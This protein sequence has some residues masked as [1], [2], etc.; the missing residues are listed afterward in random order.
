MSLRLCFFSS[1]ILA[2]LVAC[3]GSS[4]GLGDPTQPPPDG[5]GQ[6]SSGST[7]NPG[8][9]P[10]ST[11]PASGPRVAIKVRGTTAAVVHEDSWSGETPKKQIVAIRS[12]YLLR[13]PTDANPVQVFDHGAKAVESDLISGKTTEVASVI[14][15]T[16]P[17]GVFTVAKA[18]VAYVRYAV[19]ARMHSVA[20]VDCLYDNVQALSDGAV[21]DGVNR[22]KG[23]F[24]YSFVASGTTYGTLEGEDAPVPA[25]GEHGGL[26]LDAS[27]PQAFYVFPV[28]LAIDPNV[29]QDHEV[30]LEINVHESFRWQDQPTAGYAAKVFDTTPYTFEPVM[31][32]GANSFK[33]TIGPVAQ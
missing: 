4:Y 15:K 22:D 19:D 18:G 13:S 8:D 10:A 14:A 27:G 9:P 1:V 21:I 17:A 26:T 12:L 31:A 25:V 7:T 29:K 16:L 33:L 3:G 28:Q 5:S 23:Y 30:T 32:F 20:T 24:R 6:G 2:T 11:P